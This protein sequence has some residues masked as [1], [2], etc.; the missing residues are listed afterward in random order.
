MNTTKIPEG[1]EVVSLETTTTHTP[2]AEFADLAAKLTTP[3]E[4]AVAKRCINSGYHGEDIMSDNESA[5]YYRRFVEQQ[6]FALLDNT[7][8]G[9]GENSSIAAHAANTAFGITTSCHHGAFGFCLPFIFRW[10]MERELARMVF[11]VYARL[12]AEIMHVIKTFRLQ[13][14]FIH[15]AS[16]DLTKLAYTPDAEMGK[17]DRQ[18]VISPGKLFRK[19]LPLV[20][21][22]YIATLEAQYR[23]SI[24]GEYAIAR[25]KAAI[26]YVYRNMVGDTACMRHDS[27][28]FGLPDDVHPSHV[29]E[30]PGV[31]IAFTT[32]ST[33]AV[34][35]RAVIYDNPDDPSDKRFV[36]CYGDNVLRQLL[37]RQGYKCRGL[38]GVYLK[39]IV[40]PNSGLGVMPYIDGPDGHQS[41][42]DGTQGAVLGI[43]PGYVRMFTRAD[44]D[45]LR[46]VGLEIPSFKST[47]PKYRIPTLPGDGFTM[48]C[49]LTGQTFSVSQHTPIYALL[50]DGTITRSAQAFLPENMPTNAFGEPLAIRGVIDG[51]WRS[52]YVSPEANAVLDT[53]TILHTGTRYLSNQETI[54]YLGI[55]MLDAEL[56]GTGQMHAGGEATRVPRHL[57][58]GDN[59]IPLDDPEDVAFND[60][61]TVKTSD[62]YY[63]VWSDDGLRNRR[64]THK[65]AAELKRTRKWVACCMK[66][67]FKVLAHVDTRNL[68]QRADMNR[69]AVLGF[70]AVRRTFNG[71]VLA[72]NKTHAQRF[73]SV[74]LMTEMYKAD[75][76]TY[77]QWFAGLASS[78][79][80]ETTMRELLLNIAE[81]RETYGDS[82]LSGFQ[83]GQLKE[84]M[85]GIVARMVND[86]NVMARLEDTQG[87]YNKY[88]GGNVTFGSHMTCHDDVL[89]LG[90]EEVERTF[91]KPVWLKHVV[92]EAGRAAI[93][94]IV[95]E[96][97]QP[98]P[99]TVTPDITS[100]V[101][102]VEADEFDDIDF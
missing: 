36:R 55:V 29:Y 71:K 8:P 20:S 48:T 11:G 19:L 100:E 62:V 22:T 46:A 27:S 95:A 59:G 76:P 1:F 84:K 75:Y 81:F 33:G 6:E 15:P 38:S 64:I 45:A 37:T 92:L 54:E 74:R 30:A 21:D 24:Q 99:P 79:N 40:D 31:G 83:V 97:T 3:D 77:D 102:P 17:A 93:E 43:K 68:V 94:Q 101:Q 35:S 12:P 91:G 51:Q 25:S 47:S 57:P 87:L 34:K 16:T 85:Q 96:V 5:R 86:S 28:Y 53:L 39:H 61:A 70:H 98:R 56:Y 80:N 7:A 50:G 89:A 58:L 14:Y 66:D 13:H 10:W 32:D 60:L 2:P 26:Q 90:Q 42:C 88:V 72:A 9:L 41:I 65:V 49:G 69:K 4:Y 78:Y 52:V 73:F 23:S 44:Y 67:G 82:V 18:V 63:A